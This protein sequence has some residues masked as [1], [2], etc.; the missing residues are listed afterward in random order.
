MM[1]CK[2]NRVS[3]FNFKACIVKKCLRYTP[4]E[5]FMH[6]NLDNGTGGQHMTS[7]EHSTL[8]ITLLRFVDTTAKMDG[9]PAT[10]CVR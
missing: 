4:P 8:H 5:S 2:D 1:S 9:C 6:H 3:L 7:F 10:I